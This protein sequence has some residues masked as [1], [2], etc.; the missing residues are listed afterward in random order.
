MEG[1]VALFE[2]VM[3]S[4]EMMQARLEIPWIN[5]RNIVYH[6]VA[7]VI[8]EALRMNSTGSVRGLPDNS[9]GV[10]E[11][12]EFAEAWKMNSSVEH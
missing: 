3:E 10:D 12:S 1:D 4:V 6:N 11:V 9:I 8:A 5:T 2:A 7:A